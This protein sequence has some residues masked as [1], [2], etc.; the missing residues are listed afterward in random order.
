MSTLSQLISENY[1]MIYELVGLLIMLGIGVHL[2]DRVKKLTLIVVILLGLEIFL[3]Y[4]EKW[5]QSFERLSLL[6][7]MLT[8][9]LYSIYPIILLVTMMITV[10]Q[11]T[12]KRILLILLIPELISVPLYFTSQWTHLICWYHENNSYSGG[13]LSR[14][15]YIIFGFYCLVFLIFNVYYFRRYSGKQRLVTAYIILGALVGVLYYKVF[16]EDRDFSALF[17]SALLLYFIYLYIHR[18]KTDPLTQL[19]NRQSYYQDLQQDRQ[20]TAVVSI[21]MND[22]K[23]WN[24]N[25]GHEA[26]DTALKT[27]AEILQKNC[28][29]TG[30]VYR[31]GGDEFMIL[32]M[33]AGELSVINSIDRMV[34]SLSETP[35]ACAFGYAMKPQDVQVEDAI[36]ES[37]GK[38]YAQKEQMKK[39]SR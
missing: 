31:V 21:D 32:F 3:F 27:I 34:V 8:A 25:F 39:A 5:T 23:Y 20:I 6:R 22:L 38:M 13:P 7:P 10:E 36:R 1:V 11:R 17:S 14:W 2:S 19:L 16:E 29:K 18:S 9:C 24:D 30:R 26:G 35:Y 33:G 15:P 4:L 37:D 12:S 28:E